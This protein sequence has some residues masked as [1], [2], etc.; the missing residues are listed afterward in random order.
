M[1]AAEDHCSVHSSFYVRIGHSS[2][3]YL[4]HYRL[5]RC[6]LCQDYMFSI[7]RNLS[8]SVLRDAGMELVIISNG[9][10]EMIAS[11][12]SKLT[13][14]LQLQNLMVMHRNIS[15]AFRRVYRPTA[16]RIQCLGY[17]VTDYGS[18]TPRNVCPP[19]R[20][21]WDWYGRCQRSQG[22]HAYLERRRTDLATGRRVH[23]WTWVGL[24]L[25]FSLPHEI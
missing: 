9:A 15:N 11:Y 23:P 22:R 18:W 25:Y 2:C 14:Q 7:S 10:P 8:A 1:E 20:I 5:I 21:R 12:R 6:P 4:A 13:L 17:D 16:P 24:T 3:V 19:R